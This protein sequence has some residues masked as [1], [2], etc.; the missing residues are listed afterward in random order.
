MKRE[1]IQNT[2]VAPYTSGAVIDRLGFLS[3]IIAA[4]VGTAGDLTLTFTH[5]DTEDG[6]FEAVT[7]SYI[8]VDNGAT[9]GGVVTVPA[10]AG[11]TVN[12]DIDLVGCKQFI[13]VDIAGDAAT[14]STF[15]YAL[16]DPANAPV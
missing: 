9:T 12:V 10:E 3:A 5:S 6:T 4:A 14:A 13:K 16:G 2:K 1:L 8:A 7:D 15:A 11:D